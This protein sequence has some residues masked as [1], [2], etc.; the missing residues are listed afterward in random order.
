MLIVQEGG[1][2]LDRVGADVRAV[3]DG[4]L[5]LAST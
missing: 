1:Y 2:Q 5:E 4:V 3:L